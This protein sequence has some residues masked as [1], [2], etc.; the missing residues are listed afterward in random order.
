MT[1]DTRGAVNDARALIEG[2]V[3][4]LPRMTKIMRALALGLLT[5]SDVE[6]DKRRDAYV[7]LRE[8]AL[9]HHNH[10]PAMATDPWAWEDYLAAFEEC[11]GFPYRDTGIGITSAMVST[12]LKGNQQCD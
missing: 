6:K 7:M 12:Y 2:G 10:A 8:R 4:D 5:V 9:A 11:N 1:D 3:T